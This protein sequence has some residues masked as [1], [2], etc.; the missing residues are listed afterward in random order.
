MITWIFGLFIPGETGLAA[1][2]GAAGI[3]HSSVIRH[4]GSVDFLDPAGNL[5][6][7]IAVEFADTP[8]AHGRGLM[9]RTGLDDSM[10]MLFIYKQP[11][12][13]VFWMRNTPTSLDILFISGDGRVLNIARN[14]RPL[15]D[16]RYYSNGPAQ[17]VVEV[18]AGFCARHGIS[19][20]TRV[21]WR[22]K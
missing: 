1:Q 8:G 19:D 16:T 4:D 18:V 13:Q 2:S 6:V 17:Y 12:E 10:G 15:S 22:R 14:T 9:W 20:G 7:S 21:K 5:L 3:P 11:E